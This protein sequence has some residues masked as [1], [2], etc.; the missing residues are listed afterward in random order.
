MKKLLGCFLCVMLLVFG[1]SVSAVAIPL[2][3]NY[4]LVGGS[5]DLPGTASQS[6]LDTWDNV[7]WLINDFGPSPI[8]PAPLPSLEANLPGVPEDGIPSPVASSGSW[9]SN[10][11][12]SYNYF[13]LKAGSDT[14]AS[15]GGFALYY[16]LG[17]A[18]AGVFDTG[19]AEGIFP[20]TSDGWYNLSGHAI[21]HIRL[22]N[23]VP[24]VPEPATMFLLGTGLI[25][26]ALFG[27]QRFKK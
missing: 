4:Y 7:N 26:L 23:P 8:P 22:W 15:G 16:I 12:L 1:V 2:P 10:D 20:I 6:H 24:S 9:S 3:V 11:G 21:S 19:D 25:G 13:S 27:R 5:G 18:S 14:V 17:G